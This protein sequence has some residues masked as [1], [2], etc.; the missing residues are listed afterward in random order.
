M[1]ED[2]EYTVSKMTGIP[3]SKLEEKESQKLIKMES[4]LH[5]R[6]I[7]QEEAIKAVSRAIRRSRAGLK[8][9]KKP[10]GS[11]FFLGPTGVGKTELAKALAWFLFNDESSL[12]KIDMSEYMERFN[13]SRLTGAPPGYVGYEEGGQLTEKIR[14]RPYSVVLFDEI[15]KAH[16]DVFN[17]LLQVLDE[18]VLTDS[19]G[20]KV[21][22]KNTVII[23]T[24]NLGAR[25]IANATP[26]GFRRDSSE[27]VYEKI[28]ENVLNELKKTF[29]PEFLNR[30]DET[31]VFHPLDKEHLLSIIDLLVEETNVVLLEQELVIEV[32]QEVKEWII[33]HYYQPTYGARPMRRAV[34]KVIED[35]LSEE[36]L[37][38]RFKD[39]HKVNVV[40]DGDTP[41]FVEADEALPVMSGAN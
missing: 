11:F 2:I 10:I 18:G 8:S 34:Q 41:A 12:V 22:F 36:L 23:M 21:D 28:K 26:L 6:I 15:E 35:P 40:L 20:R 4:Y 3:L 13:V 29:N 39:I 9:G 1:E 14:K 31:V 19:Y 7:G 33:K 27:L 38:G 16:P 17:I 24:S 30:V 25:I 37:K 5:K 32:S